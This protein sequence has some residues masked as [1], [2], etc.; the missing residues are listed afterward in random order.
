MTH[1]TTVLVGCVAAMAISSTALG[2]GW[3]TT[4]VD[5]APE[6]FRAGTTHEITYTVLQHGRTPVE[7]ATAIVFRPAKGTMSS[8]S[9]IVVK[10]F[11][12]G[13]PGQYRAHVEV[14]A[15]GVWLWEACQGVFGTFELGSVEVTGS[16][17]GA[18]VDQ[19]FIG[20]GLGVLALVVLVVIL[21]R[22]R[23][24]VRPNSVP[25]SRITSRM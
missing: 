21:Y 24:A 11:P 5:D 17:T 1:R 22:L 25:A 13:E 19:R 18:S 15:P 16:V 20:A 14:P 2:G 6:Q 8:A 4:T 3:A 9:E 10:G 7:D 23:G 12:T